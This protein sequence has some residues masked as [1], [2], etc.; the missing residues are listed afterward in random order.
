MSHFLS[1]TAPDGSYVSQPSQFR[2]WISK[3]GPHHPESGRYLLYVALGCPWAHRALIVRKLKGLEKSIAVAVVHYFLGE[4]GWQ[5]AKDGS[6]LNPIAGCTPDP[7]FNSD[8][9]SQIYHKANPN[10][11]GR[12]TVPVL[13]DTRL[14]TIVS[15]ESADIIRMLNTEFNEF[16]TH[17]DLDLYPESLRGAIDECNEWILKSFNRGVYSAGFATAQSKYEEA[18]KEVCEA[19]KRIDTILQKKEYMM[20]DQL[21]EVDV[22]VFTTAIRFDPVYFGHFKCNLL[23]TKDCPGVMRWMRKIYAMVADTVDM[24]H[25]KRLYYESHKHINPNGIVPLSN[26]PILDQ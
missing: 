7:I 12:F 13:F 2:N 20:G 6:N 24:E 14:Q 19:L 21:T 25:I 10:Y 17:P 3:A 9:L 23:A 8:Y 22:K 16:A 5:F 15:N 11:S 4:K 1:R 26:G 18:A